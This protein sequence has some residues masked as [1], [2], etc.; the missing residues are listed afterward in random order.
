MTRQT[1]SSM[2]LDVDLGRGR[3][4]CKGLSCVLLSS[5]C[6]HFDMPRIF[7]T[8][9][10][11]DLTTA[12]SGRREYSATRVPQG[13]GA[14]STLARRE[15]ECWRKLLRANP[16]SESLKQNLLCEA[17][18]NRV[19]NDPNRRVFAH[20]DGV[21]TFIAKRLG[22][23]DGRTQ[24]PCRTD[25]RVHAAGVTREQPLDRVV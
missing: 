23:L 21:H 2:R 10:V 15:S 20:L 25:S 12:L 19:V 22:V 8:G 4:A 16:P 17:R 13:G 1:S 11:P 18:E 7:K 14:W 9:C 5:S 3:D 24:I 6:G